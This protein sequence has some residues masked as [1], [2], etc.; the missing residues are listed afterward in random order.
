MVE[1]AA[2]IQLTVMMLSGG[3]VSSLAELKEKFK[4]QGA[5]K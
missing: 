2:K 3:G 1:E 4:M 5:V